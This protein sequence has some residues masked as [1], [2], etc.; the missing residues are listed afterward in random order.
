MTVLGSIVERSSPRIVCDIDIISTIYQKIHHVPDSFERGD[1]KECPACRFISE[2]FIDS[3]GEEE[4]SYVRMSE[5]YCGVHR[6]DSHTSF[7]CGCIDIRSSV[8]QKLD[9]FL[10]PYDCGHKEN[11]H[12][13]LEALI[14]ILPAVKDRCDQFIQPIPQGEKNGRLILCILN[15]DVRPFRK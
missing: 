5:E 2:A 11:A 14:D 12:V 6:C 1:V 7:L 15:F 8:D 13:P 10:I 4:V 9:E 3:S